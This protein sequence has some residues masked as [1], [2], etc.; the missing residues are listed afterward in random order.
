MVAILPSRLV[1]GMA[2][3]VVSEPPLEVP[4]FT[5][6]AVWHARTHNDPAHR[7]LRELLVKSCSEPEPLARYRR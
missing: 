2:G 4:G 7:W 1:A 6:A 3:L 5:N